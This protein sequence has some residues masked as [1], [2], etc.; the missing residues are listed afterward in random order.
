M[1][2]TPVH[3]SSSRHA[4]RPAPRG[5][6][7]F[8]LMELM[9]VLT[10]MGI[11]LSVAMP[12]FVRIG[13]RDAVET[14]AYDLQRQISLAR[15]KAVSR[16]ARYRVSIDAGARTFTID[17][18]ENGSWVP[19]PGETFTWCDRVDAVVSIG[20]T[21]ANTDI[22]LEPQGTVVA[23]DAPAIIRFA[24]AHGDTTTVSLVRTGRLRI[25]T[26]SS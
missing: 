21:S 11:I 8:S 24:N 7:G 1:W 26:T 17:R 5:V 22:E 13:R 2:S 4:H 6:G 15:Q 9:V 3:S 12:N 16:R 10:V 20:G 19:D 25:S 14:A 18:R 23:T